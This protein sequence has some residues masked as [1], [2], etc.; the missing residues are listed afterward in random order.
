MKLFSLLALA[1]LT[2]ASAQASELRI[3]GAAAE[4]LYASLN[5]PEVG[6]HDEHG[7]PDFAVAKYGKHLGCSKD[8]DGANATCWFLQ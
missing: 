2:T 5:L 4:E 3:S 8:L 1:I 7:G 6:V